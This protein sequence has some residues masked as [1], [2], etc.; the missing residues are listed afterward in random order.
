MVVQGRFKRPVSG[1]DADIGKLR[2][3]SARSNIDDAHP[4]GNIGFYSPNAPEFSIDPNSAGASTDATL[5]LT[6]QQFRLG[7][8]SPKVKNYGF[9]VILSFGGTWTG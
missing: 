9:E 3:M 5:G 7:F 8:M 1:L 6:I 4:F 2:T